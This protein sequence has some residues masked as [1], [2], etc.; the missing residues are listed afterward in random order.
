MK[1]YVPLTGGAAMMRKM[2]VFSLGIVLAFGCSG[3]A[4]SQEYDIETVSVD[5][6]RMNAFLNRE[7]ER[8]SDEAFARI[9]APDKLKRERPKILDE[10]R[11]M[12]GIDRFDSH[13]PFDVTTVRTVERDGYTVQ[14]L[15]FQ[16]L[17][18]FYVTADLYIPKEGKGPF[19]AVVWGPGHSP[20]KYGAKTLRQNYAIPWV[21][22]GYIVL[23]ID[24]VQVAEAFAVHRGT[25]SWDHYDWYSRGYSPASIEVLN[26][27]KG[28]DYL[29]S[30]SDVD[31]KRLVINGVSGGGHLSWM[32]GAVDDRFTV[33]EPVAGTAD[34]RAHVQLD[35][36]AGHCDCAYFINIFRLDWTSLSALVYPRPLFILDTT[37]DRIYPPE[38]YKRVFNRVKTLYTDNGAGDKT[39]LFEMPGIHGYFQPQREQAVEWGNRWLKGNAETNKDETFIPVAPDSLS[40]FNGA[41]PRDAINSRIQDVFIPMADLGTYSTVDAWEKRK[42]DIRKNL[43]AYVFRNMPAPRVPTVTKRIGNESSVIETEPGIFIGMYTYSPQPDK[44]KRPAMLYVASPGEDIDGIMNFLRSYPFNDDETDRY[45]IYP[46]GI[47]T[48]VWNETETRRFQRCSMLLGRSVDEMRL[49]DVLCTLEY[50]ESQPQYDG[51]HLT[52]AGKGSS[53]II[54]AYS[55]LMDERV[56]RVILHSPTDSH[57]TGPIFLNILRYTDIQET[58]AMLAPRELVFLTWDIEKFAFTRSVYALYDKDS[59]MRRAETVTQVLNLDDGK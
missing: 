21:R 37:E 2:I 24:P 29:I 43:S 41:I 22:N 57:R 49:Y 31:A 44:R 38:G 32:A 48:T 14:S 50:I 51:I 8:L 47:G 4:R 3:I 18:H 23:M 54:G 20:G 5:T 19:P 52:V 30:R 26:A 12:L 27:M 33:V 28:A 16:S 15:F 58:L 46:R 10:F 39:A 25:H 42:S 53:G 45:V 56:S 1:M 35:L 6:G 17:P 9:D 55:A 7:A 13:A 36:Q 40:A 11:Y 34:V 59:M